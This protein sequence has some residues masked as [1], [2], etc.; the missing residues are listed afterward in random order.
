MSMFLDC[1]R[2]K[3]WQG[4]LGILHY[5]AGMRKLFTGKGDCLLWDIVFQSPNSQMVNATKFKAQS[6]CSFYKK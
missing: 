3:L 2:Q 6:I 5:L 4:R 1:S